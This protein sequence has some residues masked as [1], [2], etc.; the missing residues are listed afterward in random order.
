MLHNARATIFVGEL[1]F[2][3]GR[4]RTDPTVQG[5][6]VGPLFCEFFVGVS[7]GGYGFKVVVSC[8]AH[9]ESRGAL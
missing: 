6:D 7:G 2:G 3:G 8:M 4:C 5:L 1:E 9:L